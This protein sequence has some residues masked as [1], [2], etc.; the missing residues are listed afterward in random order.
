MKHYIDLIIQ[1]ALLTDEDPIYNK[2]K[3]EALK[4]QQLR[5][6]KAHILHTK[7]NVSKSTNNSSA[8]VEMRCIGASMVYH[9][10]DCSISSGCFSNYYPID[11]LNK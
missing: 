8:P 4:Q 10:I 11:S 3:I 1:E 2:N 5:I 7:N 9:P 6:Q